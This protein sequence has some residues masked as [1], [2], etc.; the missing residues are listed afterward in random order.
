MKKKLHDQQQT[1]KNQSNSS[2]NSPCSDEEH[3]QELS[4]K[5]LKIFQFLNKN[6]HDPCSTE[7]CIVSLQLRL[8]LS[9]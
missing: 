2:L 8:C 1:F 3:E 7:K 6:I 5:S 9:S 4:Q